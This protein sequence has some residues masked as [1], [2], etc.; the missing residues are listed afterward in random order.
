LFLILVTIL[1]IWE[2]SGVYFRPVTEDFM[3]VDTDFAEKLVINLDI[4]F[5]KLK[6]S[7]MPSLQTWEH[8]TNK[9]QRSAWMQWTTM[10]S[11]RSM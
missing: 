4:S 10:G 8:Q 7:G 9:I 6:C 3:M 5:Y 1:V 11:S 2:E